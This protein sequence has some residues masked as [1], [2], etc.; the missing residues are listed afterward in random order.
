MLT[1]RISKSKSN[2]FFVDKNYFKQTVSVLQTKAKPFD[3]ELQIRDP[4]DFH[5]KNYFKILIQYPNKLS[6][7]KDF[8]KLST[9]YKKNKSLLLC[10]TNLLALTL[11]KPPNEINTDII[12]NSSQ[13]FIIPIPF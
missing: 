9:Y 12:I 1:K 2:F 13:K 7:I 3:I 4:Q 8:T 10:A 6:N 5:K 11:L